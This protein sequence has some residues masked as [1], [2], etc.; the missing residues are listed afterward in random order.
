MKK[1]SM[2]T[3]AVDKKDIVVRV[4]R[5]LI[6]EKSLRRLLDYIELESIR[7]RSKLTEQQAARLAEEVDRA[8]W[9]SS[10]PKFLEE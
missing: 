9:E 4:D 1:V 3:I 8:A 7:K 6:D 2:F 10:K 5:D